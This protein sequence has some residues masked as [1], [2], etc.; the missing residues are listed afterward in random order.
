LQVAHYWCGHRPQAV[1]LGT[2]VLKMEDA[3]MHASGRAQLVPAAPAKG[4]VLRRKV[5]AF[6]LWGAAPAYNYG[7]IINARLAPFIYPR[8]ECRF[9]LGRDVPRVT[10]RLLEASGARV[11][12]GARLYRDVPPAMWRFLVADD[13]EVGVFVCRDCDARIGPKDAAAVDAWLASGRSF[14]VMRDHILHRNLMLAGLWGGRT[15]R[16]LRVAERIRRFIGA[17]PDLRYGTD[18]AFLAREVWPEIRGDSLVHDSYYTLFDAR[19]FPALG[20]GDDRHHVGMAV[21]S[22]RA[23]QREA[24]LLGLPWPLDAIRHGEGASLERPG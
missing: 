15:S 2:R 23:L 22:E 12:E 9:Y 5:I 13:P 16:P 19:P 21:M 4:R 24:A 8:W 6:S 14:H 10:R 11:V 1:E 18:Q 3:A 7:A 17:R 20:R